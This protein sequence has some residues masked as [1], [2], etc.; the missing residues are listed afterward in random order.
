MFWPLEELIHAV[1]YWIENIVTYILS[2][3][4]HLFGMAAWAEPAPLATK[5]Q[6]IF[7]TAVWIYA[8]DPGEAFLT[9]S[10]TMTGPC[11]RRI[12]S[13]LKVGIPGRW[14][15]SSDSCPS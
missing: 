5:C 14:E 11:P 2:E 4:D 10:R 9:V 15:H 3:L 6:E 13:L 1:E 7:F 12:Q 8:P